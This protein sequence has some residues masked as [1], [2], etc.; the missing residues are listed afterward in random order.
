[1]KMNIQELI[2]AYQKEYNKN[3][4]VP[5]NE[6][7]KKLINLIIKYSLLL[8]IYLPANLATKLSFSFSI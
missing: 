2:S 8:L 3:T 1:M 5:N 4:M 6:N 7:P